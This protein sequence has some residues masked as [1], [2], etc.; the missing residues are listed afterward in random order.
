ME[1]TDMKEKLL[2]RNSTIVKAQVKTGKR[3]LISVPLTGVV[4]A[5][6]MLARYGQGIPTNWSQVEIIQ[7]MDQYSPMGYLV[8]DARNAAI[9]YCI[10]GNFEWLL[11]I[12]HDVILPRDCFSKMN[13]WMMK[14]TVPIV[15]GLYFTK[16][17]PAEPLMYREYGSCYFMDWKLGDEVWVAATGLGCNLIHRSLL[18]VI[19]QDS[20]E[21]KMGGQTARRVFETPSNTFYD[22]ET[23]HWHTEGGTEDIFF[24]KRLKNENIYKRA[25][26]PQIQKKQW[27]VL[28]DTSIFCQHITFDGVQYPAIGEEFLYMRPGK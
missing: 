14:G 19:Y 27:P 13:R 12:D 7:W 9:D 18:E 11:F 8:A 4:R 23:K 16:S 2:K 1:G 20:D 15:A 6:W 22:A 25:G 17:M 21:Y 26:W 24:F 3:L 10:K 5:E 28:C